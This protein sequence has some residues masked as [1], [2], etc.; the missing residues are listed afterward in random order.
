MGFMRV[1]RGA[2][3]GSMMVPKAGSSRWRRHPETQVSSVPGF[4]L[5]GWVIMLRGAGEGFA[6]F[7]LCCDLWCRARCFAGLYGASV[8]E[9]TV[10]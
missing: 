9:P 6:R 2:E 8:T 3:K 4:R 7:A 5:F 1:D 10:A